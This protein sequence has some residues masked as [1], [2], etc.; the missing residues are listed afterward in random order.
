MPQADAPAASG[1]AGG[2]KNTYCAKVVQTPV[3][4]RQ[5]KQAEGSRPY[6]R[7]PKGWCECEFEKAWAKGET[8]FQRIQELC[9]EGMK[10]G[11]RRAVTGGKLFEIY[12]ARVLGRI[13]HKKCMCLVNMP[14][15]DSQS[16]SAVLRK[17]LQPACF[18]DPASK[19]K[20]ICSNPDFLIL[21][22]RADINKARGGVPER[23]DCIKCYLGKL[24]KSD[25]IAAV[26][27][28][29]SLRP[30]RA[31]QLVYEAECVRRVCPDVPFCIVV[32]GD[33]ALASAHRYADSAC[34][35]EDCDLPANQ[36]RLLFAS[37]S[38][39]NTINQ[40]KQLVL[41][42]LHLR[43]EG[44]PGSTSVAARCRAADYFGPFAQ[45]EAR[46]RRAARQARKASK[47]GPLPDLQTLRG[48][49]VVAA[50]A[51]GHEVGEGVVAAAAGQRT[52]VG[53]VEVEFCGDRD[54]GARA[55]SQRRCTLS[56]AIRVKFAKD[57]LTVLAPFL[58]LRVS[59]PILLCAPAA[60]LEEG[61]Q[62]V[63]RTFLLFAFSFLAN[64]GDGAA[65]RDLGCALP[66]V[67][68][69]CDCR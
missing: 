58:T 44:L 18:A 7:S 33:E 51:E 16:F 65:G 21:K 42:I 3:A 34:S 11:G 1:V 29:T 25:I 47:H 32:A 67:K 36:R 5:R 12:I 27:V 23:K 61:R 62:S 4:R 20:V 10:N 48:H 60:R 68:L 55:P 46:A 49:A 59:R 66:K 28:K 2:S 43:K 26:S 15:R 6:W 13:L 19:L 8:N 69:F 14:T 54:H 56:R 41:N 9:L 38:S 31:I 40:A 57:L 52:P 63:N 45:R 22:R 30:D 17:D 50:R 64:P 37:A 24:E 53:H 39:V 35:L